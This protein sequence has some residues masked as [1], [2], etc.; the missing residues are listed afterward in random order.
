MNE[1]N[2][3]GAGRDRGAL[4]DRHDYLQLADGLA[5]LGAEPLGI[6]KVPLHVDHQQGRP[7][8]H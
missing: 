3:G 1:A 6:E 8:R 7:A 4:K 5:P 2:P